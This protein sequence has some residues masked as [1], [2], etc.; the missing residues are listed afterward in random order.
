MSRSVVKEII[1]DLM[2]EYDIK[3]KRIPYEYHPF[4]TPQQARGS[5]R[6]YEVR[7]FA[8]F[9]CPL[10]H[11]SWASAHSWCFIDLKTQTICY[12][13]KQNCKKCESRANP[14]FTEESVEIM[15]DIVIERYLRS[16]GKWYSPSGS[17][18]N[19]SDSDGGSV[20]RTSRG[21]HD[22]ER[23]GKCRRLGRRCCD[24]VTEWHDFVSITHHICITHSHQN[25]LLLKLM[26]E[27]FI[28]TMLDR[29]KNKQVHYL[30]HSVIQ[31]NYMARF[32]VN[33]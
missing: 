13:D 27:T 28:I 2:D 19:D 16:I 32:I 8:W 7:G 21:P 31:L 22:Q 5:R 26:C 17:S 1:K 23:C 14:Q 3:A 24:W 9:H 15:A 18:D 11:H 10:K 30:I 20:Q 29:G 4:R 6:Y 33:E 12:K 25:R